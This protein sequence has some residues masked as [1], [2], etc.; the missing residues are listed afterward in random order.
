LCDAAELKKI[1]NQ[2]SRKIELKKER[3][4]KKWKKKLESI[5]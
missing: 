1:M 2:R 3:K 5:K 4:M